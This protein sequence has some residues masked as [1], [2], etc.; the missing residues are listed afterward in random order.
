MAVNWPAGLALFGRVPVILLGAFF[1]CY[2]GSLRSTAQCAGCSLNAKSAQQMRRIGDIA[3]NGHS[4]AAFSLCR[5]SSL[6]LSSVLE[7]VSGGLEHQ[8]V[9][10][11]Y[12]D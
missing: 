4:K 3:W 10:V 7:D 8:Q 12:Y 9:I 2:R 11:S 1:R 5:L 6:F